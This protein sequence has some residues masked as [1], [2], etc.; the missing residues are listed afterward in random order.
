VNAFALAGRAV[1]VLLTALFGGAPGL[2]AAAVSDR[3]PLFLLLGSHQSDLT[4]F[5]ILGTYTTRQ[6]AQPFSHRVH[7]SGG[8]GEGLPSALVSASKIRSAGNSQEM[9]R[10]HS[11]ITGTSLGHLPEEISLL[12]S[13]ATTASSPG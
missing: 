12:T 6:L 10:G 2:G 9:P 8:D 3:P 13:T 11:F 1:F 5:L 7:Y 4:A